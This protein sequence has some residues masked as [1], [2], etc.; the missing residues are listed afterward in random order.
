MITTSRGNVSVDNY[1]EVAV[2][3]RP[4]IFGSSNSI[5]NRT[6]SVESENEYSTDSIAQK[7]FGTTQLPRDYSEESTNESLYA[8]SEKT[9]AA[10]N[11]KQYD[12]A[13]F[14]VPQENAVVKSNSALTTKSKIA[15]SAFSV[16]VLML[17]ILIVFSA[18]SVSS[19]Y[20]SIGALEADA[21]AQTAVVETLANE[22]A[23]VNEEELLA[24]ATEL[25]Y[26][27]PTIAASETYVVPEMRNA[28]TFNVEQGWFDKFCDFISQAFGG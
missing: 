4:S 14:F 26:T 1:D 2:M 27:V 10:A 7:L 16:A 13:M 15:I 11:I 21:I 18:V 19:M 12:K 25:G 28:Q 20:A 3:T 8:P 22:L 5:D 17:A 6:I 24:R 9:M 23:Q